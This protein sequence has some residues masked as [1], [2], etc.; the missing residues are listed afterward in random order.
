MVGGHLTTRLSLSI[1]DS[2]SGHNL[3]VEATGRQLEDAGQLTLRH[4]RI[5]ASMRC[6]AGGRVE[7]VTIRESDLDGAYI[8]CPGCGKRVEHDAALRGA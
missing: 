1:A 3:F 7:Y 6:P 4:D 2:D 5:V 8:V